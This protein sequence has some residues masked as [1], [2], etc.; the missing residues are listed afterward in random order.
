MAQPRK[1][2]DPI[3]RFGL[4]V[5]IGSF[6]LI[7]VGMVLVRP[8]RSI[9]PYSIG[10]Q[11]G[12]MVAVHVPS[13]TSDAEIETL[14]QRFRLVARE[15]NGFG[16]MKIQ[17][18]T[19]QHPDGS[20]GRVTIYVFTDEKWTEPDVLHQ[21]VVG[22]DPG[23]RDEFR[24]AVR[25]QYLLDE[26]WEEGRIGPVLSGRDSA[27]TPAY[28]RVLFMGTLTSEGRDGAGPKHDA[29]SAA[30]LRGAPERPEPS[31]SPLSTES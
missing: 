7:I 16:R 24:K 17:P 27:A 29:E 15:P 26:S 14:I 19:P 25:G 18:T 12:T 10:S 22:D 9:P 28:A 21:Y 6:V 5:F 2:L 4:G 1:K 8:D 3:V 23:L 31:P 30:I 13:W 11:E 20:Y